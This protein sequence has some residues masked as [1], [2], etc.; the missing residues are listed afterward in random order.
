MILATCY[1]DGHC[2]DITEPHI[3]PFELSSEDPRVVFV[4]GWYYLFYYAYG[5]GESTVYLRKTQTPSNVSSWQRVGNALPW[6]RNGCVLVR[7]EPPHYVLFGESPPLPGIG[8]AATS[9]F[10]NF[11]I[12]NSTLFKANGQDD[13]QAPEIVVEASTPL[14]QLSTGDYFH[15][16]CAGTPGWV[17]NGNYTCGFVILDKTNPAVIVQRSATHF[18]AAT[19]DYELG[20]GPYPVQRHRTLFATSLIPTDNKDEFRV[21]YGAADANVAS[22]LIK[23]MKV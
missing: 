5:L 19:L 14:V 22:A 16:Y 4:D 20:T 12:L 13:K 3:L 6:H 9:D 1:T 18:F 21:W 8:I 17:P 11:K 10:E 23:V 2:D 15:I 7:S